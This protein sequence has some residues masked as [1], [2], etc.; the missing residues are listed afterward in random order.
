MYRIPRLYIH[1]TNYT[2]RAYYIR[3]DEG[4]IDIVMTLIIQVSLIPYGQEHS[5]T[6]VSAESEKTELSNIF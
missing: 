4:T 1:I 2:H 6:T 3:R 5:R